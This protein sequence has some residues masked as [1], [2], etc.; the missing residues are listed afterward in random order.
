MRNVSQFYAPVIRLIF[1]ELDR[2]VALVFL[3]FLR[4]IHYE[5]VAWGLGNKRKKRGAPY[6]N[7]SRIPALAIRSIFTKLERHVAL[8]VMQPLV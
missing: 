7:A 4:L 3:Q 5:C 6:K 8:V 2:Q 1:T